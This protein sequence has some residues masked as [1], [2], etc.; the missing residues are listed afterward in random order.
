MRKTF[1]TL[2]A[3]IIAS[4]AVTHLSAQN[5][6][7]GE[8]HA[9]SL[10]SD[11]NN[12][13]EV[14]ADYYKAKG[15]NFLVV[16]EHN[17][18]QDVEKWTAIS[19][20]PSKKREIFESYVSKYAHT[21]PDFKRF[22]NDSARV[23]LKKLAE[24]RDFIEEKGKFLLV[25]GEEIT[26]SWNNL[27]VHVNG[28]N[29]TK[30]IP[31]QPGANNTE[32][33]QNV[34]NEML[35]QE[36]ASGK[37]MLFFF[38]HPNFGPNLTAEDMM[39]VKGATMFEVSNIGSNGNYGS[40]TRDSTEVMWDKIN[41]HH[42]KNG[43]PLMYGVATDDMHDLESQAARGWVMVDAPS[44]DP[45]KLVESMEAG[46]FYATSGV[47]L[48]TLTVKKGKLSLSIKTEPGVTYKV[49]FFGVKKG[50]EKGEVFLE[51]TNT[52]ASYKL[53]KDDLFVRARII[54]S[55]PH[56]RPHGKGDTEV[57]WTQPIVN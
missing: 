28:V 42:L 27:P 20:G 19:V 9:H 26:S 22:P 24:Y 46:K 1:K 49:Q 53:K 29:M 32:V 33:L 21:N 35:A 8:M 56:W 52:S 14:I 45:E 18:M 13:P 12:Y 55:K 11:G 31:K 10:W 48:E 39:N 36:K 44:L 51:T 30:V 40:E 54:S 25:N 23:R 3:V 43:Q 4:S 50:K 47:I 17:I 57:A 6:Y 2:I 38:N 41:I 5:W 7:K 15:F 37:N 34:T 16:T